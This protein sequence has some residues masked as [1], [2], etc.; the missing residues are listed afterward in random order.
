MSI[1][2]QRYADRH[3][4][5]QLDFM[6]MRADL[7]LPRNSVVTSAVL[8]R[9]RPCSLRA[10]HSIQHVHAMCSDMT[11]ELEWTVSTDY[12]LRVGAFSRNQFASKCK[13]DILRTT[14][15]EG[16]LGYVG[17]EPIWDSMSLAPRCGR[18]C[19]GHS[20]SSPSIPHDGFEF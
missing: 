8:P 11:R 7:V 20:A 13:S 16:H 19:E 14:G 10:A 6:S 17:M 9:F 4:H 5:T 2:V 3:T 18:D 1:H 12:S 15:E